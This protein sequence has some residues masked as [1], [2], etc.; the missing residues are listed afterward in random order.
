MDP[1]HVMSTKKLAIRNLL[2]TRAAFHHMRI[3][4]VI[5]QFPLRKLCALCVSALSLFFSVA[6]GCKLSTVSCST[7]VPVPE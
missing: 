2:P 4:G 1:E 3:G 7:F 5:N 6:V